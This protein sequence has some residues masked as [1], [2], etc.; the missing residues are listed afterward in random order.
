[1]S[2]LPILSGHEVLK[3]L[4]KK[5]GFKVSRQRGSHVVLVRFENGKK[6]GTVVPLH[7]EIK[8]G[9]LMGILELA[10]INKDEF[11]EALNR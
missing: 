8:R 7:D 1:M 4:I 9:I 10:G 2:K 11:L 5:F 6:V 3:V